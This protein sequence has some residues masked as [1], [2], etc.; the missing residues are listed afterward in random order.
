MCVF[1]MQISQFE[2]EK[3]IYL[4]SEAQLGSIVKKKQR[5]NTDLQ[6]TATKVKECLENCN[7]NLNSIRKQ[8]NFKMIE[9]EH[10]SE[11]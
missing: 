8:L 10:K 7:D 9:I 4:S 2:R 11:L 6:L 5:E 3:L 1:Y